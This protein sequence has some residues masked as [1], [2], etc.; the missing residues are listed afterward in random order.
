MSVGAKE[1]ILLNSLSS[2]LCQDD[3]CAIMPRN[4]LLDCV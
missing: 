4:T 3:G 2:S 1:E